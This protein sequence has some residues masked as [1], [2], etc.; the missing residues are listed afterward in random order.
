MICHPEEEGDTVGVGAVDF[1]GKEVFYM[2]GFN[3]AGP[4]GMGPMTGW[5]QGY[6]NP[7]R[8][9]YASAPALEAGYRAAAYGRGFGRGFGRGRGVGRGRDYERG[10]GRRGAYPA[11][12][13]W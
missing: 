12:G 2:P 8:P 1:E 9:A 7:S 10:F 6:C 3:G 5:G 4:A 13:A 11:R